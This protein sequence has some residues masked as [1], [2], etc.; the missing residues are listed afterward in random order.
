MSMEIDEPV[1][2]IKGMRAVRDLID[3]YNEYKVSNVDKE[4]LLIGRNIPLDVLVCSLSKITLIEIDE[5]GIGSIRISGC[6]GMY[7]IDGW[8]ECE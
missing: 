2:P 6:A 7:S 1:A 3:T 8:K 4:I 5:N